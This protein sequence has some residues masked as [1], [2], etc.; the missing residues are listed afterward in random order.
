VE[1]DGS[2]E[3]VGFH[4]RQQDQDSADLLIDCF[5]ELDLRQAVALRDAVTP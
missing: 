4:R 2:L 1:V 3:V 5:S